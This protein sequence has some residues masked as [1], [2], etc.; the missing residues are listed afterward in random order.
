MN[1]EVAAK[2]Y[3]LR[4][5]EGEARWWLGGLATIKATSKE[6]GG[7]YTLV[8]VLEPEGE[9]PLH[10]HHREDEAFWVLE[11]EV[12]FQIGEETIE[13]SAGSF[14]FGP[15]GRTPHLHGALGASQDTVLTLAAWLRGV[16]LRHERASEGAH[17]ASRA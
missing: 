11:G 17:P 2:A 10:V 12:T 6:T 3:G 5:G 1:E 4:E 15:Q 8:E 16:H 7:H 13:A 14:V 9:A